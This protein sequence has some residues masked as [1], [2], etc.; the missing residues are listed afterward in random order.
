[1]GP[2]GRTAR[3]EDHPLRLRCLALWLRHAGCLAH[4][5]RRFD[6]AHKAQP[7]DT[8]G[9]AKV[10]RDFIGELYRIERFHA[11]LEA[12]AP[13]V[14][15]Q[16]LLG[17]AVYYTLAQWPKLTLFLSA[18]DVPRDN[19]RCENA[20]RPSAIGRKTWLFCHTV[21]GARANALLTNAARAG[22]LARSARSPVRA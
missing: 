4:A 21:A 18:G 16:S 22:A 15:P 8:I 1:M 12:L 10:T 5:R 9:H 17:R 13:Q 7:A 2:G 14:L 11:W 20:I 3:Q 19:N 6:E